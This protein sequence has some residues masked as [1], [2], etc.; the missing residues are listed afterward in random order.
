VLTEGHFIELIAVDGVVA[1][2]LDNGRFT[3]LLT[4][5]RGTPFAG[6][7]GSLGM[8]SPYGVRTS[9]PDI[10]DVIDFARLGWDADLDIVR[11]GV[12]DY[13][14]NLSQFY[15][16]DPLYFE[17]LD[18]CQSSPLECS[19]YS[20]AAGNPISFVDPSGL[21]VIDALKQVA[22]PLL[23]P[24]AGAHDNASTRDNEIVVT[25]NSAIP[26]LPGGDAMAWLGF[27]H[28]WI[29][30]STGLAAGM[31]NAQG[32][33]GENQ[34]SPDLPYIT[35]TYTVD[36]HG[37][38]PLLMRDVRGLSRPAVEAWMQL[39]RETGGWAPLFNDC[40][41]WV[42]EVIESSTPRDRMAWGVFTAERAKN[43]VVYPDGT[44][45]KAN[46]DPILHKGKPATAQPP[47]TEPEF[48]FGPTP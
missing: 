31:G 47:P 11:M 46:G 23:A 9:H 48:L 17:D 24:G 16:P 36:H 43:A 33:P 14:A 34:E 21:G 12:R 5:P 6:K 13:D 8:A 4:D 42:D 32:V 37:R 25:V 10:A 26:D 1:G 38:K 40:N 45:H 18:K 27:Y 28:E 39:G 2:V 30:T 29:T 20:Y 19:L 44:L 3:A 15:T 41:T 7:D 35:D 22:A